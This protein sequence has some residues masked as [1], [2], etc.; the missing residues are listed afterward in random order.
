[1]SIHKVGNHT[2]K[3]YSGRDVADAARKMLF[4]EMEKM[5][6]TPLS[7]KEAQKMGSIASGLSYEVLKELKILT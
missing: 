4:R 1:M 2:K 5:K 3:M 6:G 7:E